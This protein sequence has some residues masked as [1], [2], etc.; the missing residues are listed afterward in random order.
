MAKAFSDQ[1]T[2]WVRKSDQRMTAVF[3]QSAQDVIEEAQ[4]RVNVDTG[5]LRSSGDAALNKLPVVPTEPPEGA[6]GFTWDADSALLVIAQAQLGDTIFFGYGANYA[7]FVEERFGFLRLSA[8]NW[9]Q[10]VNKA[11]RTIEQRVRR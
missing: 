3:R 2:D 4:S 7:G 5:F 10:I 1:V 11:A 6:S 8:Q 9:P